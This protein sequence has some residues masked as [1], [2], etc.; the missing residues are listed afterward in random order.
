M[1]LS[2]SKCKHVEI[3]MFDIL[4][5]SWQNA[6]LIFSRTKW[7]SPCVSENKQYTLTK[8][9]MIQDYA[10]KVKKYNGNRTRCKTNDFDM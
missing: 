1:H 7:K 9:R 4:I 3:C 6:V 2:I 8:R 5:E 10:L